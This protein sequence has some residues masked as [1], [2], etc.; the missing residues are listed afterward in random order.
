[1]WD[2]GPVITHVAAIRPV[3]LVTTWAGTVK[4]PV[5]RLV[6]ASMMCCM[7]EAKTE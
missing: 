4:G 7:V 2:A 6:A 3:S 1:M 5:A